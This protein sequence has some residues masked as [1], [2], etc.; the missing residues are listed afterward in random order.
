MARAPSAAQVLARV[1]SDPTFKVFADADFDPAAFAS[2]V[3]DADSHGSAGE[4]SP[5]SR[6]ETTLGSLSAYTALLDQSI[7]AHVVE[8]RDQ[9]MGGVGGIKELQHDL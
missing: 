1:G 5:R 7:E 3:I 9:L 2:S 4:A 6:A 8:H